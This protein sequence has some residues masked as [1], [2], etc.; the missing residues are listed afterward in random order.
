MLSRSRIE[1]DRLAK[2]VLILAQRRP[3]PEQPQP[4]SAFLAGSKLY[5][6]ED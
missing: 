2:V 4:S 5:D 1:G 6:V 3:I